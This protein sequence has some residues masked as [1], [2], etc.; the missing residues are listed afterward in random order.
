[1]STDEFRRELP[2]VL[3]SLDEEVG[4]DQRNG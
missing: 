2:V 1:M 3:R 4:K